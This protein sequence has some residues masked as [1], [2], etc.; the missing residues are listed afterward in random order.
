MIDRYNEFADKLVIHRNKWFWGSSEYVIY[1]G[2][3]GV[4]SVQYQD[5]YP[6]M[7]TLSCLSVLPSERTMG[8]G[9]KLV[10]FAEEEARKN[11]RKKMELGAERNSW[12]VSWY[13]RLGYRIVETYTEDEYED[14]RIVCLMKDL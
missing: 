2:G 14:E 13:Q 12:L 9:S 3:K 5:D 11:G 1:D 7:A 10:E 8:V 6:D 4:V